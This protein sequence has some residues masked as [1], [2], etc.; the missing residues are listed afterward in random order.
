MVN[1]NVG[2]FS[3]KIEGLAHA[4]S[5]APAGSI[6]IPEQ[7]EDTPETVIQAGSISE[8]GLTIAHNEEEGD[9]LFLFNKVAGVTVPGTKRPSVTFAAAELLNTDAMELVYHP[10][11]ILTTATGTEF[12]DTNTKPYNKTIFI[13]GVLS[14]NG[15]VRD[16]FRI[17]IPNAEFASK[18]DL[19]LNTDA[20]S[21]V[22]MTYNCI[23]T[24]Y[25]GAFVNYIIQSWPEEYGETE[26]GGDE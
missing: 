12:L 18:D 21:V 6:P 13:E 20:I 11:N 26:T 4:I 7:G 8:E 16:I 5:F 19:E 9:T 25:K 24:E 14:D 10:S 17:T 23:P 1:T 22:N 3:G 2:V 15:F